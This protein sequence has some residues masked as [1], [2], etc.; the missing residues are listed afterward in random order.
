M[1]W[2]VG[3][4]LEAKEFTSMI[5]SYHH[6]SQGLARSL[7]KDHS[8]LGKSTCKHSLSKF[9]LSTEEEP[10][11]KLSF[12]TDQNSEWFSTPGEPKAH[13]AMC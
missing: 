4:S 9:R 3:G 13:L 11:G 7:C 10:Q 8:L 5:Q 1:R 2:W 12:G 6:L